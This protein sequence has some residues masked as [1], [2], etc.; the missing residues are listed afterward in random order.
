[1]DQEIIKV[2]QYFNLS[3]SEAKVYLGTLK[4]G[5]GTAYEIAK[6]ADLKRPTVYVLIESL[7]G[8]GLVTVRREGNKTL[9][10]PISPRELVDTWKGRVE[11]LESI[12]PD[13]NVFYRQSSYQPKVQVFEGYA[14]VDAVY[15]ELP[16]L[17]S[18]GNEVLLFGSIATILS[19]FEYLMPKWERAFKNKNNPIRE[20]IFDE[21]GIDE[22]YVRKRL[23]MDNPNYQIR[24]LPTGQFGKTDNIIWQNKIAIFSLDKELFVTIIESEEIV[25]TYRTLFDAAWQTA[26]VIR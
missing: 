22:K 14:G 21:P 11:T 16:P 6:V 8:K 10:F 4:I 26:K 25:K 7:V 23:A 15:N 19:G 9:C 3:Q 17:Q 13:L 5:R 18:K 2:L 12:Q 1:M 20:L 24:M